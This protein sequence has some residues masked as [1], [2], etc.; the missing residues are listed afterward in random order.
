[1]NETVKSITLRRAA[2]R[3]KTRRAP[4]S[5]EAPSIDGGTTA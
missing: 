4:I 2:A 5:A 3:E 1:M